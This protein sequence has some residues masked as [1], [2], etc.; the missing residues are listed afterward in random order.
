MEGNMGSDVTSWRQIAAEV[1]KQTD[2]DK[3]SKLTE[4]LM[5]AIDEE[6]RQAYARLQVPKPPQKAA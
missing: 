3:L 5:Q 1:A 6:T 4:E 2:S